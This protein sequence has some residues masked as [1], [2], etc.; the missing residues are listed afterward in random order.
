M[1]LTTL[2]EYMGDRLTP[3]KAIEI[4]AKA[5]FDSYDLS[6]FNTK[7][8]FFGDD[9]KEYLKKVKRLSDELG[10]KCTQSHA[11]FP[12]A[13]GGDDEFNKKRFSEV[14]RSIECAAYLGAK[15][16]VI[17]PIQHFAEGEDALEMN[18]DFYG[19][20]IPYAK[21]NGIKIA[22]ENMWGID[23][24]RGYIVKTVCSDADDFNKLI[25]TVNSE[26]L[27]GCLDLGHCGLVGEDTADMIR[28]MGGK[29]IKALH[30]HDND[31][32]H[33]THTLPYMSKMD[34]DS[35]LKA[36]ADIEYDGNFTYEA[37]TFISGLPDELL[38]DAEIFM[39]K[40]GR[41][42]INKIE[43]YKKAD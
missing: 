30:I 7:L 26:Y 16:I 25:D 15:I 41:Y 12:T 6:L 4:I 19:R 21:E 8:P 10:I 40:T 32:L 34:W 27:V 14:I 43:E 23:E 3:L 22:T 5:G 20:L 11:P 1:L 17:H 37:D 33:D 28:K 24:K 31:Y 2:T 18:V 39:C 38:L 42:M 13:I 9:Y 36:L 35:I 29:R